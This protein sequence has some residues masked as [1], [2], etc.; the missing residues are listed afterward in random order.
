VPIA[1]G[2]TWSAATLV[3]EQVTCLGAPSHSSCGQVTWPIVLTR[4][5]G[6]PGDLAYRIGEALQRADDLPGAE[7]PT[8][9][10]ADHLLAGEVGAWKNAGHL[11]FATVR[12]Q[13]L[14]V[15]T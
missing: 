10:N 9:K 3:Y 1:G 8:P 15:P 14:P 7:G 2:L 5:P 13:V 12:C 11:D 6:E 4:L